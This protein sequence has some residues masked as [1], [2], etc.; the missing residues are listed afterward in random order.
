MRR[1]LFIAILAVLISDASGVSALLVPEV[2]PI[3]TTE[4]APDSGCPVFCVRCTCA[5]CATSIESSSFVDVSAYPLPPAS[6]PPP[7]WI[8]LPIGRVADILH[9]PKALLA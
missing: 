5:C 1:V 6:V 9:V 8:A 4:S 7:G 3:G 2:C